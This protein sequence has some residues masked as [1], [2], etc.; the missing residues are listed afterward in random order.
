MGAPQLRRGLAVKIA[1]V[2]FA[3]GAALALSAPRATAW[4]NGYSC[5]SDGTNRC[6]PGDFYSCL[7][8]CGPS[9]CYCETD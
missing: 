8:A 1:V 4:T 2:G 6:V 7:G 3:I 9:G 5:A